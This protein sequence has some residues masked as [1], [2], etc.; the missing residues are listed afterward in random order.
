MGFFVCGFHVAFIT[1][2]MPAFI[3]D[4]GFDPKVGAWSIS[5]IG[6]CNVFGAYLSGIISGKM[7]MRY[8]LVIIYSARAVVITLFLWVP[9]SLVS[10]LVFSATMGF[11]WLATVPPTSGLVAVMFGTRYMAMLYG[12]VF[13]GHQVG[14][15]I[16]VWLGGWLYDRGG[17]Y[18]LVWWLGAA[19]GVMA[20][21]LH[22]LMSERSVK[23]LA[24]E[25]L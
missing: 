20:A 9:F 22:W 16:G 10:V 21:I 18:D 19:L 6:L 2:H 23:R 7:P 5:I 15:F 11:L 25:N 13:F 4:L 24:A 14:S 12:I 17:G 3:T 1:A 8:L